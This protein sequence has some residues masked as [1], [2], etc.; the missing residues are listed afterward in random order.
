MYNWVTN[1]K[2]REKLYALDAQAGPIVKEKISILKKA[3]AEYRSK[4]GKQAS[5]TKGKAQ[6]PLKLKEY[7]KKQGIK[8]K[9]KRKK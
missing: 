6:K 8:V 7:I 4:K 3:S 1:A 2:D 9:T 5:T